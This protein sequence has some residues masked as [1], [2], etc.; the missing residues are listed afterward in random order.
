MQRNENFPVSLGMNKGAYLALGCC[1]VFFS[2]TSG[3]AQGKSFQPFSYQTLSNS[4]D[5]DYLFNQAEHEAA[6]GNYQ[7]ALDTMRI[8][9]EKYATVGFGTIGLDVANGITEASGYA[10]TLAI[11]ANSRVLVYDQWNWLIKMQLLN[12]ECN[13]YQPAVW[14]S[15]G[16]MLHELGNLNEQANVYHYFFTHICT[17]KGTVSE[18]SKFIQQTRSY[19][20]EINQD[21][22]PFHDVNIP[23]QPLGVANNKTAGFQIELQ[24]IPN[25]AT[26][27]STAEI[28]TTNTGFFTIQ[29][30]DLLGKKIKDIYSGYIEAGNQKINI[31]MHDIT[32]GEYFLR[33]GSP[34][35]VKTVKLLHE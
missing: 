7:L 19:Q 33:M 12:P 17:A 4:S 15:L 13:Y 26:L 3:A 5:S 30:F 31:D 23:L 25:P 24:L 9:C 35:G 21:T 22:T 34:D 27:N 32:Q 16:N 8:F 2:A 18:F 29:L 11:N 14:V 20:K 28:S 6:L 1:A 10:L